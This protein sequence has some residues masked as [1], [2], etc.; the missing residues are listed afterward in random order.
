MHI[1][2]L[3]PYKYSGTNITGMRLVRPYEDE[4][5]NTVA[6]WTDNLSPLEV[7][8]KVLEPQTIQVNFFIIII[9]CNNNIINT[10]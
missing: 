2:N 6:Q 10:N 3:E 4:F 1:L 5:K 8:D 9:Y 7:D